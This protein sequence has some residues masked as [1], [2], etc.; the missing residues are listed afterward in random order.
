[1]KLG[2][3]LRKAILA[4]G[5][6]EASALIALETTNLLTG[7]SDEQLRLR[8]RR[9]VAQRLAQTPAISAA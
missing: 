3:H 4:A 1:M 8:L 2:A 9:R 6:E 7:V 5:V